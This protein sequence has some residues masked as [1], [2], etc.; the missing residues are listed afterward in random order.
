MF[1]TQPITLVFI[2]LSSVANTSDQILILSIMFL[3]TVPKLRYLHDPQLNVLLIT[4]K[5]AQAL[6]N[7]TRQLGTLPRVFALIDPKAKLFH[8]LFIGV[9]HHISEEFLPDPEPLTPE[10][11]CLLS[12]AVSAGFLP[13][14][15]RLTKLLMR[16]VQKGA[17][18]E[19]ARAVEI[20][21]KS[22]K[23]IVPK[24]QSQK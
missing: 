9:Y 5:P 6:S 7:H 23:I 14:W 10:F 12:S 1:V 15:R 19:I 2:G 4:P 18:R 22:L 17:P 20:N 21:P 8:P 13:P 3:R 16:S 24:P 11:Y